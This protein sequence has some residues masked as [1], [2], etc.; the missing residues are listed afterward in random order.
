MLG[1]SGIVFCRR[2]YAAWCYSLNC[3]LG[4]PGS[5]ILFNLIIFPLCCIVWRPSW[6]D[7]NICLLFWIMQSFLAGSR[8]QISTYPSICCNYS[9]QIHCVHSQFLGHLGINEQADDHIIYSFHDITQ[10]LHLKL[11]SDTIF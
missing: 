4:S 7:P 2:M 10:E 8:S 3:F 11:H 5:N 6:L 9:V 1:P